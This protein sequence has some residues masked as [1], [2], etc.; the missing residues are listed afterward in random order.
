MSYSTLTRYSQ[1]QRVAS[2]ILLQLGG[3]RFLV[4]T[5]ARDLQTLGQ[6]A[7][8]EGARGGLR[9]RI[10]RTNYERRKVN[11]VEI[12]LDADD[13][14]TVRSS[15]VRVGKATTVAEQSDVYC[16][17][18]QDVFERQTGMLTSLFPRR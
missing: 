14:Y 18:L 1:T 13:T 5:G 17:Q 10:N 3:R 11:R 7:V 2:T 4:M 8:R 16:D 6:T 12:L 15:F 9:L